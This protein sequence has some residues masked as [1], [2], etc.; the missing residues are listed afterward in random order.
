MNI[1]LTDDQAE[2]LG[3]RVELLLEDT[4]D[5]QVSDEEYKNA[6]EFWLDI[7]KRLGQHEKEKQWRNDYKHFL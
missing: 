2:A 4:E 6:I 3:E 7:L 1:E 5:W